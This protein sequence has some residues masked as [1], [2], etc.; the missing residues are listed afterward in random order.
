MTS[1]QK[2]NIV[3]VGGGISGI[4]VAQGLSKKLDHSK[5]NLILI[6]PRSHHVWLPATARMVVTNDEKFAETAMFPFDR[7]FAK[8]K[9]VVKQDKVVS[10]KEGKEEVAGELELASGETLQYRV[11]V[12]ATGSK[13]SG[14]VGLPDGEADLRQFVSQWRE[15]FKAAEDIVIVGGGAVGVELS[16]EIRDEYPDKKV[17]IVHAQDNLLNDAY[18]TRYRNCVKAGVTARKTDLVLGEFV[19]EFPLSGSGEL[20]FRSGKKLNAGLVV[21]AFGPKPNTDLIGRSLGPEALAETKLVKVEKTLQLPSHPVI[22]AVG[23]IIDWKEQKQAAKASGHAPVVVANIVNLLAGRPVRKEYEG[24]PEI[25]MITNGRN[26]GSAYL[27]FLWGIILGN[28][29]MMF[30]KSRNLFTWVIRGK[31]GY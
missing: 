8:G 13:W 12:L 28:F 26:G 19:V 5:Y 6:E 23:D 15:K 29:I 17:T 1:I 16:G 24:Y 4:T 18:P 7:V 10:I 31:M 30:V 2:Q 11:L 14:P 21:A 3:V 20:V 22:F 27:P 25:I 9:G